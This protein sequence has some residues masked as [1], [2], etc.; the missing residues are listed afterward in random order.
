MKRGEI[1]TVGDRT[2]QARHRVIVLSGEGHND[3]PSAS[4]YCAP[5]VRQRGSGELP[6]FVVP[7][8]ETDPVTGVVVVNRLRRVP[9][10]VA[11]ERVGMATGASMARIG[12]ALRDLFEW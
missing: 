11:V 7:L 10:A 12:E 1:W 9:S 6:P 8:A 2:Q 3:R 5:I 4:P